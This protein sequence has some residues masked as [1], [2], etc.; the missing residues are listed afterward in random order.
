MAFFSEAPRPWAW[1]FQQPATLEASGI[2]E[3]YGDIM[4]LLTGVGASTFELFAISA[5]TFRCVSLFALKEAEHSE[6][7]FGLEETG[8]EQIDAPSAIYSVIGVFRPAVYYTHNAIVE[9][10]WTAVPCVLLVLIGVPSF[11]LAM[12]LDD[13]LTPWFWV[14]VIG[15]QWFWTYECSTLSTFADAVSFESVMLADSELVD[16][17]LRLLAVDNVLSI[18]YGKPTRFLVTSNDVIH[19]WTVPAFGVKIDACP[20]RINFVNVVPVRGGMFYGQCSEI[21]GVNHAFM[22]IAVQVII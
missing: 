21:C 9:F 1:G 6:I 19:S 16:G 7:D 22:P 12:S 2:Q 5:F 15:N 4:S 3:L 14:K 13:E 17:Y 20:G 18:P 8:S 11:T 10:T